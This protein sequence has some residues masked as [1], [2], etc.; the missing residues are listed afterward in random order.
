MNNY[1][2]FNINEIIFRYAEKGVLRSSN[3]T[4]FVCPLSHAPLAFLHKIFGES[5][6][7]RRPQLDRLYGFSVP[8]DYDQLMI[9]CNGATLFDNA[10]FIYGVCP[11]VTRGLTLED[12]RPLSLESEL[13]LARLTRSGA[14][15]WRPFGAVTGYA[16][17]FNLELHPQG[18][19]RV[20]SRDGKAWPA[21]SVKEVVTSLV[22]LFDQLTDHRG[23]VVERGAQ[24]DREL[25]EFF[26][27]PSKG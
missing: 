12:Q 23:F 14:D 21:G 11:E 10:L 15:L 4:K 6:K 17:L 27:G 22:R 9:W 5:G 7:S 13:E 20:T 1:D 19:T 16:D 18:E 2:P 25:R 3:G 8:E 24:L 26:L